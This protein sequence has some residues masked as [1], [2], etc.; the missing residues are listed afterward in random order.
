MIKLKM[1]KVSYYFLV[2]ATLLF[3]SCSPKKKST[4]SV[5]DL[6]SVCSELH[7]GDTLFLESGT[8]QDLTLD[9]SANGTK[10]QPI[11]ILAKNSGE[12]ILTGGSSLNLSGEHYVISGIH[13]NDGYSVDGAVISFRSKDGNTLA[14]GVRVTE[15]AISN[16]SNPDRIAS[17]HWIEIFG[18]ENRFDHNYVGTKYNLGATMV[19]RL[20]DSVSTDNRNS[21]DSNYFAPKPRLGS[22]GGETLRI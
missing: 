7:P 14:K 21:I 19:M 17:D 3:C 6:S 20:A 13:F 4:L 2:L 11:Y 10:E 18:R 16:Y 8:F 22:N 12:V 15:C 1:F 5:R 9:V